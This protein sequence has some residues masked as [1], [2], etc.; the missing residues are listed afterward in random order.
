MVDENTLRAIVRWIDNGSI[1]EYVNLYS[2][3]RLN[4]RYRIGKQ[5]VSKEMMDDIKSNV[6]HY[7]RFI[8][9]LDHC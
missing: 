6:E 2:F 9:S 5:W 1:D 8:S 7:R 3:D 4:N